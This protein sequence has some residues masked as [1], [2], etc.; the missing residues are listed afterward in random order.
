MK[1][2]LDKNE[3][4]TGAKDAS[5]FAQEVRI[6][7]DLK[8]ERL[9]MGIVVRTRPLRGGEKVARD[10]PLSAYCGRVRH[11]MNRKD[12]AG[13]GSRDYKVRTLVVGGKQIK[14]QR[15]GKCGEGSVDQRGWP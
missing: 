9:G 4:A 6:V 10:L 7:M 15:R 14:P 12:M 8:R 2:K 1:V 5:E 11:H 3:Y 13:I